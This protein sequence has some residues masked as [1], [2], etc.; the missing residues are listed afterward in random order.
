[1]KRAIVIGA[2][3]GGLTAAAR[4]AHAGLEVEL[5]EKQ[6]GP[7]GRC[8]RVELGPYRF[9]LGPTILL[10][11]HVLEATFRAL[12]RELSDYLTLHRCDP[13][14]R[15]SFRDGAQL[16]VRRDAAAMREEL[17][18][19]EPGAFDAY[20][21]FIADGRTKHDAA[22]DR[23][24]TRHFESWLQL[25]T[26]RLLRAGAL[27]TLAP[28]VARFFKGPHLRQAFSF[29]TMYL[30]LSPSQAP[31]VFSLLPYTEAEHGIWFPE[32]GLHAVPLALEKICREEGVRLSY[33]TSVRRVVVEQGRAA[34]VEL[35]DGSVRRADV[36]ICN[37]DYAWASR[38]LLPE[39]LAAR[40]S[41]AVEKRR[42]TSSGL[43]FYFGL[44]RRVDAL[45]HHNVFLGR[46]FDGS[47]ADIFERG[48][49]PED[50]SFYVNAPARTASGFAPEGHDALYV[51]VPAPAGNA[52]V[53]VELVRG[54]VLRR[55]AEEGCDVEPHIVA[56]R[57]VAPRDWESS[58]NLA[59]G[60]AF[61]LAQDL[62][63]IGPFRPKVNDPDVADLYWCGASIQPGTGV[64]T[65]MLSA[66]FAVDKVLERQKREA[67]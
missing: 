17:E 39:P 20:A 31:S 66:G 33:S 60:S 12:G 51:L 5:Y 24:V 44:S 22:F 32:G 47:F 58:L 21:R 64:P 2:G 34:G 11:P 26:P 56:E 28:H 3:V 48:R 30:G 29:Q 10:M 62:F 65:V 59:R 27:G 57:V 37:A 45:L 1:M 38:W 55:L 16:T 42:F 41:A 49:M 35:A 15:I 36:V 7:G 18:R 13:H 63:Q 53:D 14:Y 43:M 9:D 61:G 46:D 19:L 23:F 52:A 50:P 6:P 25:V 67:A 54:Q 8:G 4:L 40:R